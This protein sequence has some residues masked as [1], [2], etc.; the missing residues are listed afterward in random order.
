M[1]TPAIT[2]RPP[3]IA[4]DEA[5]VAAMLHYVGKRPS[6]FRMYANGTV[7]LIKADGDTEENAHRCLRELLFIPDFRVVEMRD[8]NFVVSS[9][10]VGA[11]LVLGSEVSVQLAE[12]KKHED[13][14]KFS[15]EVFLQG[16]RNLPIGLIGRAKL[17]RDATEKL[18]VHHHVATEV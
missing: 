7:L 8:G 14:A 10:E 12:L 9:H 17:W 5:L 4:S 11:V 6:N 18:E 2:W 15:G 3:K 13:Q 16:D 1:E